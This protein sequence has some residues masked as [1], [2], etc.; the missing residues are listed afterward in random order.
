MPSNG[1]HHLAHDERCQIG[2]LLTSGMSVRGIARQ[3]NR[4]PS[5]ISR[6]VRRNLGCSG[7]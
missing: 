3:L 1:Y 7:Y 2:A 4:S 5:A 6:E